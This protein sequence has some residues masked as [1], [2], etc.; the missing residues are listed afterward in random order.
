MRDRSRV[1]E[2]YRGMPNIPEEFFPDLELIS[3][4][5]KA[6]DDEIAAFSGRSSK[7]MIH[8]YAGEARQVMRARQAQEKRRARPLRPPRGPN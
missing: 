4:A 3:R 5:I 8:K 1:V 6:T 2:Q 7:D